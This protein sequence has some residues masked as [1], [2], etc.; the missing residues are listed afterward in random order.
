MYIHICHTKLI[1]RKKMITTHKLG[2]WEDSQFAVKAI[3]TLDWVNTR[4]HFLINQ[5]GDAILSIILGLLLLLFFLIPVIIFSLLLL[6]VMMFA[7]YRLSKACNYKLVT[8]NHY[9]VSEIRDIRDRAKRDLNITAKVVSTITNGPFI[10]SL[11]FGKEI[12]RTG[13]IF[14]KL[15]DQ[16]DSK[17]CQLDD[18]PQGHLFKLSTHEEMW[19]DRIKAYQ[20]LI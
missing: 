1:Q 16:L 10:F 3:L 9:N 4:I 8:I 20:Y 2:M 11:I 14:Q 6:F 7:N 13:E 15:H 19:E 18:A 5:L 12:K 17:L